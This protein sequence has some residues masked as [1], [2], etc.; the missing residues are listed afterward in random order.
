MR[1]TR[2]TWAC[3]AFLLV[4]ILASRADDA[5]ALIADLARAHNKERAAEKLAPLTLDESLTRAARAHAEDMAEH[6]EMTHEGS[7]G[8]KPA[9]RVKKVGYRYVKT[10]ENVAEGQRS[11]AA[12]MRSWMNS[13]GHK[14]NILGEYS[15][16]GAA[17]V[18][19]ADGQPYWCVV[20]GTPI[21]KLDPVEAAK[22]ALE[23]IN[24]ARKEADKEP[25]KAS[26]NLARV[27]QVLATSFAGEAAKPADQRQQPDVPKLM[28]KEGVAFKGMSE[29]LGAG[30]PTAEDFVKAM[31]DDEARKEPLMGPVRS[32]GIGYARGEDETPY[33]CLLL[34][35][36]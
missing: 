15:Q 5:D 9:E 28:K 10:G 23:R 33:W 11:V 16:M 4:T 27:A 3:L 18:E 14:R 13:P 8:S 17:M 29:I 34:V 31:L 30:N 36:E 25:L 7:D 20:F 12:V 6:E 1:Y 24:A 21:P 35:E 22:D 32:V 26:P 2:S 19:G